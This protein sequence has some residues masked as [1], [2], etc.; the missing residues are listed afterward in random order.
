MEWLSL[1]PGASRDRSRFMALA[2]AILR[3]AED[4][5][6]DLREETRAVFECAD[7]VK[8]AKHIASEDMQKAPE[9]FIC[10]F[11]IWES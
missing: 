7:F 11:F 8:F 5:P 2:E 6:E 9:E 10:G 3:Q 1:F 4:L